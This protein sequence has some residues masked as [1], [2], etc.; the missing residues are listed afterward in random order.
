MD[1]VKMPRS[2]RAKQFAPFDALKGLHNTILLKEFEHEKI[3]RG[4]MSEDEIKEISNT[5]ANIKKNDEIE[6]EFFCDGHI[7]NLVGKAR[8]DI[9]KQTIFV[10]V[11]GIKFEDIKRIKR[12][13]D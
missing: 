2:E 4:E 12:L 7:V 10:G 9:S 13:D 6:I 3:V 5:L 1:R 8:I 11:F